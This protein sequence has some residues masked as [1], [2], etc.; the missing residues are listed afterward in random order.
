M[1]D[2][3]SKPVTLKRLRKILI[4]WLPGPDGVDA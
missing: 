1:V 2:F 3:M 4:K